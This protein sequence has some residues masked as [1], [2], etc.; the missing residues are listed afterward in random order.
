[1]RRKKNLPTAQGTSN[2]VPWA[3]FPCFP[4]LGGVAVL[5]FCSSTRSHPASSCSRRW[6]WV[7]RWWLSSSSPRRCRLRPLAGVVPVPSPLSSPFPR[8][9]RPRCLRR[10]VSPSCRCPV[11]LSWSLWSSS[12]WS[13]SLWSSSSSCWWWRSWSFLSV[14]PVPL[15]MLPVSTPRAVARGGGSGYFPGW[16]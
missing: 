6:S 15:A 14:V 9:C 5:S 1:M 8:R 4:L 13:S 12:L 3:L 10:F 11:P 2:D 16:L 7:P